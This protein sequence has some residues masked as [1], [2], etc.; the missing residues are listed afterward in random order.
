MSIVKTLE[1]TKEFFKNNRRVYSTTLIQEIITNKDVWVLAQFHYD[2]HFGDSFLNIEKDLN[3]IEKKPI[4]VDNGVIREIVN[5]SLSEIISLKKKNEEL[6][7]ELELL[8]HSIIKMC[9]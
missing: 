2:N 8:K 9:Q 7:K 6:S 5:D 4:I 1:K 3:G